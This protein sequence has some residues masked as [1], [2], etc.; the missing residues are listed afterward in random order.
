ME[1]DRVCGGRE[2]GTETL[3]NFHCIDIEPKQMTEIKIHV[4]YFTCPDEVG[5]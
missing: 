4:M 1:I 2:G 3:Q 5:L